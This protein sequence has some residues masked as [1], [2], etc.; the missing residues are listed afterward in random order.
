MVSWLVDRAEGITLIY[1]GGVLFSNVFNGLR[2]K[3]NHEYGAFY[4]IWWIF[5]TNKSNYPF[6]FLHYSELIATFAGEFQVPNVLECIL[7]AQLSK[8]SD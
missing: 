8:K 1:I 5:H 2:Q 4:T 6:D 7:M 3:L